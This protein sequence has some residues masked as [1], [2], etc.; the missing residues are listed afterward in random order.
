MRIQDEKG[1]PEAFVSHMKGPPGLPDTVGCRR[2]CR[3][4]FSVKRRQIPFFGNGSNDLGID[5]GFDE[6][7]MTSKLMGGVRCK[8]F[9]GIGSK[10]VEIFGSLFPFRRVFTEKEKGSRRTCSALN[11]RGSASSILALLIT[12]SDAEEW[13]ASVMC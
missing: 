13:S 1:I 10:L 4:V 2:S 11:Y 5:A 8:I 6:T 7:V 9:G 3:S 12:I